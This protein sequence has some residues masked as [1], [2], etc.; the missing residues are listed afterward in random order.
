MKLQGTNASS[1]RTKEKIKRA[2][3]LE[4][5][6]KSELKRVSITNLVK[7]AE[8]TRGAFYSHYDNIYEVAREIQDET[9]DAVFENINK[10]VSNNDVNDYF[11]SVINYF[12]KHEEIYSLLLKS[13][14][15]LIFTE[16]ITRLMHKNL[17]E[18]LSPKNINNL[19]LNITFFLDGC[20]GLI[21]K[22]FRNQLNE[23]LDDINEYMKTTFIKL[24][25][26]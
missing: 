21:I 7:K 19:S 15:V 3:A 23:T 1:R 26:Q 17:H 4:V 22:Y 9:I 10:L 24:F 6:E 25:L 5:K 2:F 11:D 8:I 12:K 16:R 18:Y 20:L 13:E 14:D